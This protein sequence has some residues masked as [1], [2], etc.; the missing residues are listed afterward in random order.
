MQRVARR[1][2]DSAS[3]SSRLLGALVKTLVL[4]VGETDSVSAVW[5]HTH[6]LLRG[7]HSRILGEGAV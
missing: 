1:T 5:M 7:I 3:S 6:T 2:I 4:W